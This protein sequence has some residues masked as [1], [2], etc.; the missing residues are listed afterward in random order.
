MPKKEEAQIKGWRR[1]G[2]HKRIEK[3]MAREMDGKED[4][5]EE[6]SEDKPSSY[7]LFSDL[8]KLQE[9]FSFCSPGDSV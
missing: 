8:T 3:R 7:N 4:R 5:E 9:K 6:T 1:E 2:P